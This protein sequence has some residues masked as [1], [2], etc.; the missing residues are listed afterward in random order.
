MT[1]AGTYTV[2]L[3]GILFM[4]TILWLVSIKLHNASIV[5]LFWGLGFVGAGVYYFLVSDD[6][7]GPRKIIML[8]LVC[9]WGIRL[10]V[11]LTW[12]NYGKGEDIRYQNFRKN[13]GEH[14]YWWISFFQTFLLQGVLMWIISAPLLGAGFSSEHS[15]LNV[16]DLAGIFLCLFGIVFETTGD[17]QLARFKQHPENKGKVMRSGLWKYTRHPNYFGDS[18][19]WWGF[20]LISAAAGIYWPLISSAIMTFLLLK[21]SGVAMLDKTMVNRK[22]AYRE[23]IDTTSGF[24]PW[25]PKTNKKIDNFK[26]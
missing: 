10:S 7:F 3:A 13:Y 4:M 26:A 1:F 24:F 17:I 14:R 2:A 8:T 25:F 23:Y 12:R 20:G 21:V 19:V 6:G 16:L 11:Y 15:G 18:L 9:I 22:P 5:D